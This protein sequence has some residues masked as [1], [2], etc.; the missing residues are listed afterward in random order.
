MS[1]S[2]Q[3]DRQG[4]QVD[5]PQAWTDPRRSW[6][7]RPCPSRCSAGR[8][9]KCRRIAQRL[10]CLAPSSCTPLRHD[11]NSALLALQ[12]WSTGRSRTPQ[13]Q[14]ALD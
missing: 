9:S 6:S 1:P 11:A 10:A 14:L 5:L 8:S 13:S 3:G 4:A 7:M 2:A 12:Q